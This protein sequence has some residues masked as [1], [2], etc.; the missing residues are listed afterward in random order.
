MTDGTLYGTGAND[1]GELGVGNG[2]KGELTL[3][4]NNSGSTPISI[5]SGTYHTVVLMENGTL[6][7]TGDNSHGELGLEESISSINT[8]TLIPNNTGKIPKYIACG[9]I[10]WTYII[11]TDGTSYGTGENVYYQFAVSPF[12]YRIYGWRETSNNTG[13]TANYSSSS[14]YTNL[15]LMTDG[16]LYGAGRNESGQLATGGVTAVQTLTFISNDVAILPSM[17]IEDTPEPEPEPEPEPSPD[18]IPCFKEDTKILTNVG[19]VPIQDLKVGDLVKTVNHDYKPIVMIG[20]RDMVNQFSEYRHKDKLYACN[21]NEYPEVFEELVITGCH[22]ILVDE[23]QED[24]QEKTLELLGLIYVTDNKYRLPA[25]VS[26]KTKT[27]DSFGKFT[28]Y[29]IALENDDYYMN[30]GIYANGLLV[31]TCS[32]RY[33]SELSGMTLKPIS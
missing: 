20:Y 10:S 7:G 30:Y 27:Y 19:Y 23:F 21:S 14:E 5:S 13:K 12:Q 24:E 26:K 22:S 2:Y 17:L 31:E 16:S 25:C 11:M 29:H 9:G 1:T 8:L 4:T 15:I 33:L 28:I 6:Y 18:N 32:K 3:I